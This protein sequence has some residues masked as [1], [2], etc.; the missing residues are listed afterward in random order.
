MGEEPEEPAGA[1][2]CR[3]RLTLMP[4]AWP[5]SENLEPPSDRV[6]HTVRGRVWLDFQ[7]L[8]F[9]YYFVPLRTRLCTGS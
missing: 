2:S 9:L 7:S 1:R 3:Q 8:N 4:G 5:Y 6:P